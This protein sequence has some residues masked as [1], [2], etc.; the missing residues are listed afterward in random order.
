M[1]NTPVLNTHALTADRDTSCDFWAENWESNKS[2]SRVDFLWSQTNVQRKCEIAKYVVFLYSEIAQGSISSKHCLAGWCECICVFLYL[3]IC[4]SLYLCICVCRERSGKHLSIHRLLKA[5]S[6]QSV[7]WC[8]S[9]WNSH[10]EYSCVVATACSMVCYCM[11]WCLTLWYS[12][13]ATER[14]CTVWYGMV[15]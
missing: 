7:G 13:Y 12:K 11:V 1:A 8:G 15:C 4:V 3:C 14:C 2:E 6:I 9:I 5:F 10:C